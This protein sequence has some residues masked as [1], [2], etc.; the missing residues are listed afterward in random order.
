MFNMGIIYIFIAILLCS[1]DSKP[2]KDKYSPPS[3]EQ[4]ECL[5]KYLILEKQSFK[6]DLNN[7][8][9]FTGALKSNDDDMLIKFT[10]SER[11]EKERL[12]MIKA[13]CYDKLKGIEFSDCI[14]D[15]IPEQ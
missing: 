10:L 5:A 7:F 11:R 14:N 6:N 9:N 12:C 1:C 13:N 4:K 15:V 3:Q 8:N 2:N